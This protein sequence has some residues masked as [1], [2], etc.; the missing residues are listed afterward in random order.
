MA[1]M[2]L[3]K[4]YLLGAEK[5]THTEFVAKQL[6]G[7]CQAGGQRSRGTGDPCDVTP[8]GLGVPTVALKTKLRAV[9]G[10]LIGEK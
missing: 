7:I 10:K 8:S 6:K 4:T 1:V 2:G 9:F 5:V 3:G